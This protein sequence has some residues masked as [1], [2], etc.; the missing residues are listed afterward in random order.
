ME[1]KLHDIHHILSQ[2]DHRRGLIN[3]GGIILRTVFGTATVSDIQ[4]IHDTLNELQFQNFDIIHSLSNQV[5]YVK[6]RSTTT[7]INI[8]TIARLSFT[9]KE[10]IVQSHDKFQQLTRELIWLDI[11]VHAQSELFM[12]IRQVE[13]ALLRLIEQLDDCLM[14]YNVLFKAAYL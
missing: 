11:T 13:F 4:Q 6:K 1:S 14:L 3:F 10:N 5:T 8:E 12:T 2:L 9:V 7:E